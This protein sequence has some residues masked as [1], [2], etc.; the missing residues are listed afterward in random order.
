MDI[1]CRSLP[2]ASLFQ[3]VERWSLLTA[4]QL[5][6]AVESTV[7]TNYEQ[8]PYLII[9]NLCISHSLELLDRHLNPD[10]GL[11]KD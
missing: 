1:A 3:L 7:L 9:P 4:F 8:Q 2:F 5:G 10:A 11:H 6:L